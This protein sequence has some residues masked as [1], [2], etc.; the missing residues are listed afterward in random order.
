MD[1]ILT[2]DETPEKLPKLDII[3]LGGGGLKLPKIQS[4]SQAQNKRR[5]ILNLGSP[6]SPGQK[7]FFVNAGYNDFKKALIR[8]GWVEVKDKNDHNLDL[9]FTLCH[10]EINHQ[11]L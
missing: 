11:L 1:P 2:K 10:S 8:R 7:R 6:G 3:R 4:A 5:K 9:K